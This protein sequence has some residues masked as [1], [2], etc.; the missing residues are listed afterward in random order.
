MPEAELD[1]PVAGYAEIVAE[2]TAAGEDLDAIAA[3][4]AAHAAA[5]D[6]PSAGGRGVPAPFR[7]LAAALQRRK[8]VEDLGRHVVSITWLTLHAPPGGTVA[9][10]L[11]QARSSELG[12]TLSVGTGVGAGRKLAWTSTDTIEPAANCVQLTQDLEVHA[13]RFAVNRGGVER[14][15]IQ[16]DVVRGAGNGVAN[17]RRCA[18]CGVA[19]KEVDDFDFEWGDPFDLREFTGPLSREVAARLESNRSFELAVTVPVVN[20]KLGL[21]VKREASRQLTARCVFTGGRVYRA[22]WPREGDAGFPAW[23]LG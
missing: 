6:L 12:F 8:L 20:A 21:T 18:L 10:E 7:A 16:L 5:Y 22:Y 13:Q 19:A 23:A 15:E 17:T 11:E 14:E 3:E 2:R 9:A 1:E 4:L